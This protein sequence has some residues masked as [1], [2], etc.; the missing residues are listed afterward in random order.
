MSSALFNPSMSCSAK[1]SR[2]YPDS[3]IATKIVE[4]LLSLNGGRLLESPAST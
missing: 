4:R 3:G 1:H 2:V